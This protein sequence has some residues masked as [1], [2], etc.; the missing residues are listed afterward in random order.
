MCRKLSK[1]SR[2]NGVY[3]A[4]VECVDWSTGA[5]LNEMKRLG[6]DENTLIIMTSDNGGTPRGSNGPLRGTKGTTWEGGQR[7]PCVMRWKETLPSGVSCSSIASAIDFLPTFVNLAGGTVP[8]E[9]TIDGVDIGA[10]LKGDM[11]EQPRS[12]FLY[13]HKDR[14]EAVRKGKYKLHLRKCQ[15]S[16]PGEDEVPELYDLERDLSESTD[17]SEDYPQIVS[18]LTKMIQTAR[19]DL[20]D[21]SMGIE[22]SGVRPIGR[23]DHPRPLTVYHPDHPYIVAEYD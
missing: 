7:V 10:L 11:T 21:S 4:A 9:R 15:G 12:T 23:V 18:E 14:I 1:R 5:I 16:E 3:G 19:R 2:K 22:G 20:G 8:E 13:C 6:I 17:I